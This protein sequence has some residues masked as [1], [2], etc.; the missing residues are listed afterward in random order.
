MIG[1]PDRA[2]V[3]AAADLFLFCSRTDTYGQVIVEAQASGLPV[4]AVDEGGPASLIEDRQTGWLCEADAD[5]LA[6]AGSLSS[7][8]RRSCGSGSR[9]WH[10]RRCRGAPGRWRWPSSRPG[11]SAPLRDAAA[12]PGPARWRRLREA[13]AAVA[14]PDRWSRPT[15]RRLNPSRRSSSLR[16]WTRWPRV[17]PTSPTRRSTSTA[18]SPGCSSTNACSSLPRAHGPL[19]ERLEVRRDL[20]VEPRRVLHDPRC[21]PARLDR[22]RRWSGAGRT[23]RTAAGDG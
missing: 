2:A 12:S 10:W 22:R 9:D 4:V 7:P 19:L 5:R 16:C 18:S 1:R 15:P 13:P 11:T 6:S 17:V 14:S 3:A 23:G 8:P 20:L 21:R